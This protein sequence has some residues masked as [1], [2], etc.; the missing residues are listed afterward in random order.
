MA[1]WFVGELLTTRTGALG[2]V[3]SITSDGFEMK[4]PK[5][6][7]LVYLLV[8]DGYWCV[9]GGRNSSFRANSHSKLRVRV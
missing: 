4:N 5:R 9:L 6:G 3:G 1:P 7:L 8:W 2:L